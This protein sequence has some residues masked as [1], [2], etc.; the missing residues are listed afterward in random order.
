[1]TDA[2]LLVIR[3]FGNLFE[4]EIAQSALEAAGIESRLRA[5]DAGGVQPGLWVG[6]GVDLLVDA[7]DAERAEEVLT[8][9]ARRL[10]E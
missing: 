5:D 2:D 7:E 4:A 10:D 6:R 8:I 1:M 9:E 3:K